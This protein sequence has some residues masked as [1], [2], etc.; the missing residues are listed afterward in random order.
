MYIILTIA[1]ALA[2][3]AMPSDVEQIIVGTSGR[4]P[5]ILKLTEEPDVWQAHIA[6]RKNQRYIDGGRFHLNG[7][8]IGH[9]NGEGYR[10]QD[11]SEVLPIESL[12][13]L[14][15]RNQ[16]K[17]QGGSVYLERDEGNITVRYSPDD[18]T[19]PSLEAT[20]IWR[21]NPA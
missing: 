8:A 12:D 10:Y 16:F 15:S 13:Q 11:V 18:I 2:S 19:E 7:L 3:V 9:N 6:D 20:V 14:M 21:Q 4:P 5:M 17:V 1:L